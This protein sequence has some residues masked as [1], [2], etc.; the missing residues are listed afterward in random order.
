MLQECFDQ[1]ICH[2]TFSSH[3]Q[4]DSCNN[5]MGIIT[6]RNDL[7]QIKKWN[8]RQENVSWQSNNIT[9]KKKKIESTA[10]R[11]HRNHLEIYTHTLGQYARWT[12]FVT[13]LKW[14]VITR[15][16]QHSTMPLGNSTDLNMIWKYLKKKNPSMYFFT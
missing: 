13:V 10:N 12:W 4:A 2:L 16:N 8:K 1:L 5:I 6:S 14:I 7:Q 11:H 3:S 9:L 15:Q